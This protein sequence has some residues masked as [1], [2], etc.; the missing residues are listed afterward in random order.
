MRRIFEIMSKEL[1]LMLRSTLRNAEAPY[2]K[3][4]YLFLSCHPEMTGEHMD[5]SQP[6]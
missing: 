4:R 2:V 1:V 3:V 6:L 5:P